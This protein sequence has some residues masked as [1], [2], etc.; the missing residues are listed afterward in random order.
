MT[1][2]SV[3]LVD[4]GEGDPEERADWSHRT[5]SQCV[6]DEKSPLHSSQTHTLS[7]TFPRASL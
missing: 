5:V 1:M 2:H 7:V 3:L 6:H 4:G